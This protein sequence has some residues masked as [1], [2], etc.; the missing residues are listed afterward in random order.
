MR[1]AAWIP[2]HGY[3]ILQPPRLVAMNQSTIAGAR[4]G[5]W[6]IGSATGSPS[7]TEEPFAANLLILN[8]NG[9]TI[10]SS[11][12]NASILWIPMGTSSKICA[13]LNLMDK[14]VDMIFFVAQT[15]ILRH[16]QESGLTIMAN[17]A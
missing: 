15:L 6:I 1:N 4:F 8:R 12:R 5:S 13:N 17:V 3:F 2:I 7:V 9:V 11:I 10:G 14:S 16:G